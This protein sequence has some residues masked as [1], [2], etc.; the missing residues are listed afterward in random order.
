MRPQIELPRALN[1]ECR[2]RGVP[3]KEYSQKTEG[4]TKERLSPLRLRALKVR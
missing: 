1:I 3:E 2:E 4:L